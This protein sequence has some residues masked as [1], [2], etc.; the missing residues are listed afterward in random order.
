[1]D[2]FS[3]IS[4]GISFPLRRK[5]PNRKRNFIE[6][7]RQLREREPRAFLPV[8][9]N[10]AAPEGEAIVTRAIR[11][12]LAT[13]WTGCC[14]PMDPVGGHALCCATLGVYA[15]HKN[16]RDEVAV[17]GAGTEGRLGPGRTTSQQIACQV[18][19]WHF[20][21]LSDSHVPLRQARS[22]LG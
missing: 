7:P 1:M 13:A 10:V 3:H 22:D 19:V 6:M 14:L 21:Q 17:L 16:T 8:G 2:H 4:V 15:R 11:G 9:I 5:L 20:F 12:C 18:G